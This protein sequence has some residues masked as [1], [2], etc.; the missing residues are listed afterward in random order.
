MA[1][2]IPLITDMLKRPETHKVL[3]T[4]TP[5][6]KPHSI[7]CG[8]LIVKDPSTIMVGQ[9]YLTRTCVNL[10]NNRN[11][12][13]LVWRGPDAYSIQA[14]FV[15]RQD[16]GP[17]MEK[18]T[19]LLAKMNMVPTAVLEFSVDSAYYE[20]ITEKAGTQVL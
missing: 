16:S 1:E 20:G 15:S 17:E 2:L 3:S 10:A 12:E 8:S 9:V 19:Q 4:V 7:V 14:T 5:D 6:G 11:V 18:M 13:F